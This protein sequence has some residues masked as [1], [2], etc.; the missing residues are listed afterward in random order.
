MTTIDRSSPRPGVTVLTLDRPDRTQIMTAM[1]EDM[2]GALRAFAET[3]PAR[4]GD[5]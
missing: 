3:R 5:R 1:T 2:A 4:F